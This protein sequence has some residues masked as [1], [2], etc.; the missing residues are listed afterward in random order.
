MA[1]DARKK[2]IESI[3]RH[4]KFDG[5]GKGVQLVCL[6]HF[7]PRDIET[8]GTRKKLYPTA[9]PRIFPYVQSCNWIFFPPHLNCMFSEV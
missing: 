7:D 5:S 2:W 6:N 1:E 8:V 9:V 4:Q 3:A